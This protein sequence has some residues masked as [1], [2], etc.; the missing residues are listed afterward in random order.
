MLLSNAKDLTTNLSEYSH[1]SYSPSCFIVRLTQ[2][3][4]KENNSNRK[5]SISRILHENLNFIVE[6]SLTTFDFPNNTKLFKLAKN[7]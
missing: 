7:P 6:Y 2:F 4:R 3:L 5:P 1:I